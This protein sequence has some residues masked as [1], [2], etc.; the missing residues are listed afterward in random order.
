MDRR[1]LEP[2]LLRVWR[3]PI[4]HILVLS[5]LGSPVCFAS[6]LV[7]SGE[8]PSAHS[9]AFTSKPVPPLK[10]DGTR[11]RDSDPS[12][13]CPEKPDL[14]GNRKPATEIAAPVTDLREPVSS[15]SDAP[16]GSDM[17]L[18]IQSREQLVPA[19]RQVSTGSKADG[20]ARGAQCEEATDARIRL[21]KKN[22]E[23]CESPGPGAGSRTQCRPESV[24]EPGNEQPAAR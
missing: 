16:P 21:K 8:K 6:E 2:R 3:S 18:R 20:S 5:I 7:K 11:S 10:T 12:L 4:Q 17:E 19:D 22:N 23:E 13:P 14:S 15:S 24:S 9:G 1:Y